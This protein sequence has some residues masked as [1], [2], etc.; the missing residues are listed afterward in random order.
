MGREH[1]G[2][3][4]NIAMHASQ[5]IGQRLG[6]NDDT[7]AQADPTTNRLFDIGRHVAQVPVLAGHLDD[8]IIH[9][10]NTQC[11]GIGLQPN[12][13]ADWAFTVTTLQNDDV[14]R[15]TLDLDDGGHL[16][17]NMPTDAPRSFEL[18]KG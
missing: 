7:V 5:C 18:D 8:V 10:V 14:R 11:L 1:I 13:F 3:D 4:T 6:R 15:L 12:N 16:V 17:G 9:L 2:N